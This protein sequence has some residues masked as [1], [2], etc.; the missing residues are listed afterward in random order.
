MRN[1]IC[2]SFETHFAVTHQQL[3]I[4]GTAFFVVDGKRYI[5]ATF[6]VYFV[7]L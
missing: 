4:E 1:G 6:P 5:D 7:R 3:R 2:L